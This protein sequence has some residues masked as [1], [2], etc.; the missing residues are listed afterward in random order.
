[1]D[2]VAQM[3]EART[4]ERGIDH[5]TLALAIGALQDVVAATTACADACL[6][7]GGD[8][9]DCVRACADTAD[10]AGALVR[11][12]SRTGAT[13]EGT[14]SLVQAAA[15]V[16]AECGTICAAHGE[17]DKHCRICAEV[18]GRAEQAL[19]SLLTAVAAAVA[20]EPGGNA[21]AP[22]T[23]AADDRGGAQPT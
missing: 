13:T 8:K 9:A 19:Q 18:C 17:H 12:L 6:S 16:L 7:E 10:V 1:M 2:V 15:K 4:D 3:L 21:S 11:V 23:G 22:I 5:A 20:V 14:R